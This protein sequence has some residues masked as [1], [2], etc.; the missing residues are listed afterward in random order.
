MH[1]YTIRNIFNLLQQDSKEE[2]VKPQFTKTS[3]VRIDL[4][5]N[6]LPPKR[7]SYHENECLTTHTPVYMK[8]EPSIGLRNAN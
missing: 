5:K 8:A 7:M 1:F 3:L 2:I 6:V 4:R